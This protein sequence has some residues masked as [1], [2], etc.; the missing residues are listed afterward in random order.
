MVRLNQAVGDW[1]LWLEQSE[2]KPTGHIGPSGSCAGHDRPLPPTLTFVT[3][4]RTNY[5]YQRVLPGHRPVAEPLADKRLS[6]RDVGS[7]K[8]TMHPG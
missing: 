5:A 8:T 7:A 3:R 6:E 4:S 1:R 2:G